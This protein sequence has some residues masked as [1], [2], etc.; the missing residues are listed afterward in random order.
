MILLCP[1]CAFT[2]PEPLM[3]HLTENHEASC[4]AEKQERNGENG[5]PNIY[6]ASLLLVFASSHNT[7]AGVYSE[8]SRIRAATVL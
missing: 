4:Q 2:Q 7:A 5:V 3:T 8:V 6:A 1:A